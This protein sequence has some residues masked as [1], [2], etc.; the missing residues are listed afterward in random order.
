[1]PAEQE[2]GFLLVSADASAEYVSALASVAYT[3]SLRLAWFADKQSHVLTTCS[4][5]KLGSACNC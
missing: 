3:L 1:M 5:R 2:R 4:T